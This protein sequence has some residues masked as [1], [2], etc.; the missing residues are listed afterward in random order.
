[1]ALIS[2]HLLIEEGH[3]IESDKICRLGNREFA[4]IDQLSCLGNANAVAVFDQR[5]S[6]EL[7]EEKA[8]VGFAHMAKRR[9]IRK[10]MAFA[11]ILPYFADRGQ[12]AR[13]FFRNLGLFPTKDAEKLVDLRA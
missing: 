7:L 8:K 6:R 3:V 12:N 9:I 5:A 10:R 11:K 13:V 4:A 1:M 2:L